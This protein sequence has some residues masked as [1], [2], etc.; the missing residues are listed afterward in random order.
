[1]AQIEFI[2]YVLSSQGDIILTLFCYDLTM[3]QL[4]DILPEYI[5][6]IVVS[7]VHESLSRGNIINNQKH[8]KSSGYI[9]IDTSSSRDYLSEFRY[10][11]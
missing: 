7:K 9:M 10:Y 2:P 6:D 3:E 8:E 4:H 1:M 11:S 5:Y